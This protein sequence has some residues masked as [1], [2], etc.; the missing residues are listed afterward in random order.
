MNGSRKNSEIGIDCAKVVFFRYHA[1][2]CHKYPI[3]VYQSN[4]S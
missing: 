1:I 2:L 4:N 3:F